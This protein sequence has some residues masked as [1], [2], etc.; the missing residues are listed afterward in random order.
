MEIIKS[1]QT[2][3]GFLFESDAGYILP[4]SQKSFL[5]EY[6]EQNKE[7]K[8]NIVDGLPRLY[9]VLQKYGIKNA[10]G[11]IYTQKVLENNV[12]RYQK[13]IDIGASA[14]EADHPESPIISSK[15][16]ALKV[17]KMWWKGATLLGEISLPVSRGFLEMGV[18]ST[19]AD[20]MANH[21]LNGVLLGVS[22]R[23][24]GTVENKNGVL[25]VQ[26][27]FELICWDFV[28]TPSTF[29]AWVYND[30]QKTAPHIQE[31]TEKIQ[32]KVP[33]TDNFLELK[34][35]LSSF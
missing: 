21:I 30:V 2:G 4:E 13:L 22:S 9:C 28:T 19:P 20:L 31:K 18:V 17:E 16:I 24:V 8:L 14:G 23:G 7:G 35:F 5:L 11:R 32:E 12:K 33:K 29:G 6:K 15:N 26:D 3:S 27:D 10:N 34:N 1:N 25:Y